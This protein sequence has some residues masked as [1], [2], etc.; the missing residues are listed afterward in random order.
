[1][2]CPNCGNELKEGAKFCVECGVPITEPVLSEKPEKPEELP[3]AEA[4]SEQLPAQ[5]PVENAVPAAENP[6]EEQAETAKPAAATEAKEPVF[7]GTDPR[8]LLTTAQYFFLMILF[9]IP[10]I[11][12]IFLFVWGIGR[13]KNLSLKRFSL[14]MLILRL[15]CWFLALAGVVAM[16]LGFSGVIPGFS[17]NWVIPAIPH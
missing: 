7:T 9:Q 4:E 10:V 16:L 8:A 14:A 3:K 13:P 12:L 17:L 11:G 2:I 5:A 1:M 15:V 6:P